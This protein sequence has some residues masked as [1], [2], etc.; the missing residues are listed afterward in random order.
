MPSRVDAP[1]PITIN[2]SNYRLLGLVGQGQFGQ[3]FCAV[4]RSTGKLVALKNLEQQRFPTRQFLRELRFLLSLQ[5]PN[6]VTCLAIEHTSTGRYLVMD[7]CE[8]GTLRQLMADETQ[9]RLSCGLKLI[10]DILTGLQ[11]AHHKNIVHCD[12]KPENILLKLTSKGWTAKISDFGVARLSQEL[13][14]SKGGNTGSPA[15]MAP[16]RFYGQYS[17]TADLY[18]VGI[19]LFELLAGYRPFSGI[20]SVLMD[21]HLNQAVVFPSSIPEAIRPVIKGALEKLSARRYKTAQDMLSALYQAADS[22]QI[23]LRTPLTVV[24]EPLIERCSVP[25]AYSFQSDVQY[26][27]KTIVQCFGCT[28]VSEGMKDSPSTSSCQNHAPSLNKG[29]GRKICYAGGAAIGHYCRSDSQ[30]HTIHIPTSP[31]QDIVGTP[32]AW[33]AVTPHCIYQIALANSE[34]NTDEVTLIHQFSQDCVIAL[35]PQGTWAAVI[36]DMRQVVPK[37]GFSALTFHPLP[38]SPIAMSL[39]SQPIRLKNSGL[40]SSLLQAIALDCRHVAIFS[41]APKSTKT[42]KKHHKDKKQF[43]KTPDPDDPSSHLIGTQIEVITRRGNRLGSL[44]IPIRIG[45]VFPTQTPYRFLATDRYDTYSI[46]QIDLKPFRIHRFAVPLSPKFVAAAPW[47]YLV[48]NQEG[49]MV[50][51]DPIGGEMN[52]IE[53][54][55]NPTAIALIESSK[56]LISTWDDNHGTLYVTDLKKIG[57]DIV[58]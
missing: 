58:F 47:G 20:P 10:A 36:S 53:G 43:A 37:S 49:H 52:R 30:W 18:S 22:M 12:I 19:M 50:I 41:D 9:L 13:L 17:Q 24:D 33:Y 8:G 28:S 32:Q 55:A 39:Q 14:P 7:Y 1:N 34:V 57:L 51:L 3:V 31:I 45:Q 27:L 16:E 48:M 44:S 46:V 40:S 56:L 54:P 35:E 2:A 38:H 25:M 21:A 29:G 26:P 15:Y 42:S 11:H 5:H 6:I 4:H 23:D